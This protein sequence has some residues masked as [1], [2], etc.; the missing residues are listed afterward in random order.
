M[1]NTTKLVF[2]PLSGEF[3]TVVDVVG[4]DKLATGALPTAITIASANI[5]DGSIV[6]IDINASAAIA[7]TKL[8]SGSNSH[9]IINDGSGVL[10]SEAQ[11]AISRGGTNLS[12]LGTALQ[13][14]RVNA[15][16]TALEYAAAG[17][18]VSGAASSVDSE[19]VLFS[20]TTGKVLKRA[21]GTGY[22]KVTSGVLQTPVATIPSNDVL[23]RTDGV[24]PTAGRLGEILTG[25]CNRTFST[26]TNGSAWWALNASVTE[27]S[28]NSG[29]WLVSWYIT[30]D[31]TSGTTTARRN[32][33]LTTD[34]SDGGPTFQVGTT[35]IEFLTSTSPVGS[36]SRATTQVVN[37]P[38]ATTYNLRG[39]ILVNTHTSFSGSYTFNVQA[40]RI[41]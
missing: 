17:G 11:L 29:V 24:T 30:I 10:S 14:L 18:D 7:R 26:N 37:V 40:V 36:E 21:T 38:A 34:T 4:L 6:N 15:G 8:A 31:V 33:I 19:I 28:I 9:V 41:A 2:N 3:D 27:C 39:K 25:T 12:A 23:G 35:N 20:S 32:A 1:P 22:A 16:A 13:V 5:V